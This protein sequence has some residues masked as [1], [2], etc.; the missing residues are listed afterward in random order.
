[1]SSRAEKIQQQ[2]DDAREKVTLAD[3]RVGEL[4]TE[5]K[6]YDDDQSRI[7][8]LTRLSEALVDV[9]KLGGT[10]PFTGDKLKKTS[11]DE[12]LG[13]IAKEA[14]EY[15]ATVGK[16][17]EELTK[18]QAEVGKATA[19]YDKVTKKL[20]EEEKK[21]RQEAL[22]AYR[23]EIK[24]KG[25]QAREGDVFYRSMSLPWGGHTEDDKRLRRISALVFLFT[26][27]L[28]IG[29]TIMV[30][31]D[32][33]EEE[34]ELP[35][36]L[37]QLIVEREKKQE[38]LQAPKEQRLQKDLKAREKAPKPKTE[39]QRRAREKAKQSGLL[40]MS[41]TFESLKQNSFEQKLGTQARISTSGRKASNLE[42]S[43]VASKAETG[44]G[45][46]ITSKLSRGTGGT[47]LGGRS[48]SRVSS[49]LADSVAASAD[50]RVVGSGKASRTDE[51]IQIVFDRN[52]SALYRL[53]NRELR[54]DPT[55]QGKVVLKLTIAPS[56]QV[57]M[58]KV[59]SS[60]LNS[61]ALERKITQRVKLFNF[62]KK[63]VDAV[64]IT[65]P[66][67]FLPA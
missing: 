46:I 30:L 2:I 33:E 67:D 59:V 66:I 34:V 9:Q 54:A 27:L 49:G 61:P 48:T 6:R 40:A 10:D 14:D 22:A 47:S 29:I 31:P 36:R 39:D 35:S 17:K 26:L 44:S 55:L 65:Y 24:E 38:P 45:G 3:R 23:R 1:V 62:G 4:T 7:N 15:H 58:C 42:R 16:L 32:I 13:T 63:D 37:A 53:Y 20:E 28:S 43:I 64:T 12:V 51:E 18:A 25:F 60:S 41:D 19:E 11:Y 5:L 50:R 21:R 8:A 56:G 52:K 57:T